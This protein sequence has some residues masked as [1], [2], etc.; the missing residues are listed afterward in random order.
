MTA[1]EF[2]TVAVTVSGALVQGALALARVYML[3]ERLKA[4]E[5]AIREAERSRQSQGARLGVVEASA[6]HLGGQLEM[7]S[8]FVGPGAEKK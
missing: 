6:D 3:R 1:P 7:L 5:E 8:R 2:A 4:A